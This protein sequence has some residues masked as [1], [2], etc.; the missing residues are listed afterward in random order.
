[1]EHEHETA[2]SGSKQQGRGWT[3]RFAGSLRYRRFTDVSAGGL[4][5]IFFK[6]E[7]EPGQ[8]KMPDEVYEVF[9]S[10]KSL[11]RSPERGGGEYPTGLVFNRSKKHGRV[12]VLP[13]NTTG[14]TVADII[15]AKLG[16][17]ASKMERES[18][19]R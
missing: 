4:P 15:D 9:H 18:H 3:Q 14:R 1:M 6:V 19:H 12:W 16:D 2:R 8:S 10:L 5:S 11:K 13:D 7:L 17:L